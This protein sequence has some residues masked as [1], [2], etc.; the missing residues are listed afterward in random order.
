MVCRIVIRILIQTV[1]NLSINSIIGIYLT[2][3][4][5]KTQIIDFL[6]S[7]FVIVIHKQGMEICFLV[8]MLLLIKKRIR[9]NQ[10]EKE[11][12]LS[13]FGTIFEEFEYSGLSSCYFYLIFVIR[14]YGLVASIL[15][16]KSPIFKIL[17]SAVFSLFV[18]FIQ[19]NFYVLVVHPFKD[20]INQFYILLNESLTWIYF[21]YIGLQYIKII[22]Y[23]R[24]TQ[25]SNCITIIAVAL[26]LNCLFALIGGFYD[27]FYRLKNRKIVPI[28]SPSDL[29][30]ESDTKESQRSV[31]NTKQ[32][33]FH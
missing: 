33:I 3:L 27:C 30:T 17:I 1:F 2:K 9:V 13:N 8:I 7:V 29:K 23:D 28:Q 12:F 31:K 6:L 11:L 10:E 25:G 22:E 20:K 32:K 15:F 18:T 24:T 19:V 26:G 16:F 5:N 21:C 14:R 4:A